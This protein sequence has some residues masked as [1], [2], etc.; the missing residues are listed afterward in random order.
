M[1]ARGAHEYSRFTQGSRCAGQA[2]GA[3]AGPGGDLI[4]ERAFP[5]CDLNRGSAARERPAV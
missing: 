4:D 3:T 5:G 2:G 1:V